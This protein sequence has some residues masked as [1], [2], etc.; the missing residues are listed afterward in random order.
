MTDAGAR[1]FSAATI[2]RVQDNVISR[3]QALACGLSRHAVTHRIRP[4]GPRQRLLPGVYLAQTGPPG[5]AQKEM[6]ALLHAGRESVLTGPAA[7]RLLAITTAEPARF[8]VLVP[9][10]RQRVSESF[11]VIHRTL[12]MP[13]R[14]I[15]DGLRPYV[16]AERALADTAR[17]MTELREVR[18]L[19]AGAI[20]RRR[21][22]PEMLAR[23]LREGGR[24]NS[25]L[26]RQV[27]AEVAVGIRSVTEAE[28]RDL[29]NR[30]GLPVPMFNPSLYTP[31]GAFIA[32][33]DAWW[34]EPGVAAE[35]DSREWHLNP[36]GWE[37]TM[38]RHDNMISHGILLLHFSPNQIRG[39]PGTVTSAIAGALRT[40]RARPA[41]TVTARAA[42]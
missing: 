8:D 26:L 34:P 38:R 41:L 10:D 2:L 32:S 9:A 33:P 25:G 37:R 28:F 27:L 4:G 12:R 5:V 17:E 18:A 42:A 39:D 40:G 6:A 23:E 35:V 30:A 11:A 15:Q 20:Q 1:R 31:S 29:I 36:A 21:C 3:A 14:F 13:E 24:R 16:L 22:L 7:L 19:I